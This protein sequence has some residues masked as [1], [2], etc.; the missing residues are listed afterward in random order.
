MVVDKLAIQIQVLVIVALMPALDTATK[1]FL[2]FNRDSIT[3][4]DS[5]ANKDWPFAVDLQVDF[6]AQ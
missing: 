1:C 5:A 4:M 6:M 3:H 2:A